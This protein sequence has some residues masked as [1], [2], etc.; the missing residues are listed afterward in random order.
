MQAE[1]PT[2]GFV[3]RFLWAI[4]WRNFLVSLFPVI[5]IGVVTAGVLVAT[6]HPQFA[7]EWARLATLVTA[8]IVSV[9]VTKS[10]IGKSLGGFKVVVVRAEPDAEGETRA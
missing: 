4:T 6:G 1:I 2:T 9:P 8:L 3:V 10:V 5:V 7:N